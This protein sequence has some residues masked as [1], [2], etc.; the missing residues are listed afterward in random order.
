MTAVAD[1]ATPS[2]SDELYPETGYAVVIMDEF[3]PPDSEDFI[4]ILGTFD[5]IDEVALPVEKTGYTYY[6]HAADGEAYSRD[7]WPPE[8]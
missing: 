6:V 8:E 5:S 3:K 7:E 4:N 2:D 1:Y